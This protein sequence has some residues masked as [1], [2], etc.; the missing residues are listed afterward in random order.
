MI[1]SIGKMDFLLFMTPVVTLT[2]FP[3]AKDLP[4][5]GG[6]AGA[7]LRPCRAAAGPFLGAVLI[8]DFLP[9][10]PTDR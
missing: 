10:S 4:T 9:R 7:S 1:Y 3:V 6:R 8:A 2:D 5:F